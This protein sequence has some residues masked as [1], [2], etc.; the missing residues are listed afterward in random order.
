MAVAESALAAR[1]FR[2]VSRIE[3]VLHDMDVLI[4][5]E[6]GNGSASD[7]QRL[8]VLTVAR[9]KIATGALSDDEVISPLQRGTASVEKN[10]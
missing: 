6:K 10:E 8:R 7:G 5:E 3:T 1:K 2:S 4:D 9:D